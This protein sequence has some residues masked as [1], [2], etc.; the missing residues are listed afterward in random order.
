VEHQKYQIIAV[1]FMLKHSRTYVK[2]KVRKQSMFHRNRSDTTRQAGITKSTTTTYLLSRSGCK[3]NC[4]LYLLKL[5]GAKRYLSIISHCSQLH[6]QH[7]V[8]S[9]LLYEKYFDFQLF[10]LH[11]F[12][13]TIPYVLL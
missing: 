5:D 9:N 4:I 3:N 11:N 6:L 2:G 12:Q 7:I 13:G 8:V 1:N 10:P